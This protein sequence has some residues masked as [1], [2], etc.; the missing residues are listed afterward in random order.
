[1]TP[2]IDATHARLLYHGL[3]TPTQ[4]VIHALGLHGGTATISDGVE[5]IYAAALVR[6]PARPFATRIGDTYTLTPDGWELFY[7]GTQWRR[8]YY[9]P[10]VVQGQPVAS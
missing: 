3:G 8:D 9:G 5:T 6:D 1:M 2:T 7:A 4:L 10:G